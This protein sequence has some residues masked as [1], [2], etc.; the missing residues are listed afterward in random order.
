MATLTLFLDD[1]GVISNNQERAPQWQ[2]FVG[3]FF[4]P[5]L[6]GS[7]EEWAAANRTVGPALFVRFGQT[8]EAQG[9]ADYASFYRAYLHDWLAG[10]CAAVG[11]PCPPE[12]E[13]VRLAEEATRWIT[14]RVRAPL[15][16]AVEAIRELHARG[17]PLYMASGGH[18]QELAGIVG[19]LEVRSCFRT[20]YGPDLLDTP[21]ASP[22][23]YERLFADAGV[24]PADALVVDDSPGPIRWASEAGARAILIGQPGEAPEALLTLPALSELPRV[25]EDVSG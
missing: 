19:A 24:A 15:P 14:A 2:R 9:H 22:R 3:E 17:I 21:K 23:Y 25:L 5:R 10:M 20:L 6:G 8:L 16:G 18:S 11:V 12:A 7:M 13:A 1:G 4:V